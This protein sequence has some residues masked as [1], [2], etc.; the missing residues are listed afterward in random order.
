MFDKLKQLYDSKGQP[1]AAAQDDTLFAL[2]GSVIGLYL[3]NLRIFVDLDGHYLG[4][5]AFG[6]R[7][8][9]RT[10]SMRT[11]VPSGRRPMPR[12]MPAGGN[13]LAMRHCQVPLLPG[14]TD[15]P[16]HRLGGARRVSAA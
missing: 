5:I 8:V 9:A 7:L 1:V 15:V 6:N 13:V 12:A 16:R 4:E 14:Q 10:L 11:T 2:D 3:G